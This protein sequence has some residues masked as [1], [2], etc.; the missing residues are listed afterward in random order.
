MGLISS[1]E[2]ITVRRIEKRGDQYISA[3][4]ST[5]KCE[6]IVP[7]SD[8]VRYAFSIECD[9]DESDRLVSNLRIVSTALFNSRQRCSMRLSRPWLRSTALKCTALLL[10]KNNASALTGLAFYNRLS[11]LLQWSLAPATDR[12]CHGSLTATVESV[13]AV[14]PTERCLSGHTNMQQLY[15]MVQTGNFISAAEK[16][17]STPGPRWNCQALTGPWLQNRWDRQPTGAGKLFSIPCR[18]IPK[19]WKKN[20][21]CGL[22]SLVVFGVNWW[23]QWNGP[24]AVLPLAACFQYSVHCKSSRVAHG[25]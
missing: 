22:P 2:F 13:S 9:G 25:T 3:G 4:I 14:S 15:L 10:K 23:V 1:R 16:Y 17:P 11:C 20:G 21:T 8:F 12:Y 18:V 24:R 7:T 6:D 19:T 5:D